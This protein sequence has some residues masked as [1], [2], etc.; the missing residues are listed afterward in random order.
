MVPE[1]LFAKHRAFPIHVLLDLRAGFGALSPAD[2][3]MA[4]GLSPE[5]QHIFRAGRHSLQLFSGECTHTV[6]VFKQAAG[7]ALH[8]QQDDCCHT[9]QSRVMTPMLPLLLLP[10]DVV[11]II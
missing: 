11:G 2:N 10:G 5:A 6:P 3:S 8:S 4:W 9:V 1:I 7:S